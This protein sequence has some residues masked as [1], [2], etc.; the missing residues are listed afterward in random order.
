[1]DMALGGQ[2]LPTGGQGLD[3]FVKVGLAALGAVAHESL[4]LYNSADPVGE[5]RE[6]RFWVVLILA[7]IIAVAIA[8]ASDVAQR[9]EAFL[10]GAGG[11]AL[12]GRA[13]GQ[14][15]KAASA[16]DH[17]PPGEGA[18]LFDQHVGV[19]KPYLTQL[20]KWLAQ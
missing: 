8:I 2:L 7:V 3:M 17:S 10:L 19:P 14:K 4:R 15:D 12:L 1:M 9:W 5:I 13:V 18:K 16:T 6:S 11:P 20:R